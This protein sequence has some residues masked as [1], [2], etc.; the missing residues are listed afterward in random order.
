MSAQCRICGWVGDLN[1][2]K[3]IFAM[4]PAPDNQPQ[5]DFVREPDVP[6]CPRCFKHRDLNP[7]DLKT[8]Q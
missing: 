5:F 6:C 2:C 7:V 3:M 1:Q 8:L 4:R